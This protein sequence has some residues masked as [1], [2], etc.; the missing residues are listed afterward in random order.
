M[1]LL[2][3]INTLNGRKVGGD[4]SRLSGGHFVEIHMWDMSH[5]RR[6]ATLYSQTSLAST[7]MDIRNMYLLSDSRVV[8]KHTYVIAIIVLEYIMLSCVIYYA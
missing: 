3:S 7:P 6:Q 8:V 1:C 5:L 4:Y 2:Y